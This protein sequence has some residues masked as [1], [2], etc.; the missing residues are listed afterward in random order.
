MIRRYIADIAW[1]NRHADNQPRRRLVR[2]AAV[3]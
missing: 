1:R 2:R 3:A